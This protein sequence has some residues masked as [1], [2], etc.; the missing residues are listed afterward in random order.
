MHWNAE[1]VM[2][3]KTELEHTLH[4]G[5]VNIRCIQETHLQ[6]KKYF[7]V[8]GYQCFRSDRTD[9]NK[10]GVLTLARNNINACLVDTHMED[11][12]YQVLEINADAAD[13]QLVNIYCP[14]DKD[15]SLDTINTEVSNFVIV[16]DFSNRSQ[17]LG[18]QHMD[19]RGEEVENWQDENS[20]LLI[21]SPSGQPTFYSRRWHTTSTPDTALCTEDLHGS[22][23]REVGEQ[24]GA[25]DHRPVFLKLNLGASKKLLSTVELQEGQLDPL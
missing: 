7:K 10:G 2:N 9:R 23:R 17:S 3:K 25:S 11:S 6:S 4:E 16:G 5:S 24:L 8:R 12:E 15:L 18:Y 20:L 13:I 22:I 21:N 1:H 19:R 14:N